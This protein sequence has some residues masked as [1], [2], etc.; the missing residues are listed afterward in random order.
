MASRIL[1]KLLLT[2]ALLCGMTINA[3][4][5]ADLMVV[6]NAN[7]P[8]QALSLK[9]VKQIFLGRMRRFPAVDLDVDALD[10][11]E[12]SPTYRDFYQYVVKVDASRLKRYRAR[13]LFSGQGRLPDVVKGHAPLLDNVKSNVNAVAYVELAS[14]DLLPDGVKAVYVADIPG[15]EPLA[16]A[17]TQTPSVDTEL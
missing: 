4:A 2:V 12:N 17:A 10:R 1:L 7:N 14:P 13:Y 5:R 11:E 3:T 16:P 6:V 8:I 15:G 9:E